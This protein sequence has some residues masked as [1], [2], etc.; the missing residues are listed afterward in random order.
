VRWRRFAA[1]ASGPLGTRGGVRRWRRETVHGGAPE[2]LEPRLLALS[3]EQL[4]AALGQ[5]PVA[6][7]ATTGAGLLPVPAGERTA[8]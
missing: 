2:D 8:G 5:L 3:S 1:D 4:S 6:G 7:L